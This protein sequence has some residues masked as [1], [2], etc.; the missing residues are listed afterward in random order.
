M[1]HVTVMVKIVKFADVRRKF[2]LCNACHT[3][4]SWN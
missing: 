2:Y 3:E 4:P 1:D